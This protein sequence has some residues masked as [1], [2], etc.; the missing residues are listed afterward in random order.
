MP[1]T[2]GAVRSLDWTPFNKVAELTQGGTT[3]LYEYDAELQRVVQEEVG[4]DAILYL[5][6]PVTGIGAELYP[7][8]GGTWHDYLFAEGERVGL[9]IGTTSPAT[10]GWQA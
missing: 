8:S 9:R 7:G 5:N 6:D 1:P 4:G 2:G 3:L 10:V